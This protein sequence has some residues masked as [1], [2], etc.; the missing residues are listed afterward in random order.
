MASQKVLHSP[1]RGVR[2]SGST[3]ESRV[4]ISSC[5]TRP[6]R[7]CAAATCDLPL[8]SLALGQRYLAAMT[9][10]TTMDAMPASTAL[11]IGDDRI[12]VIGLDPDA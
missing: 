4:E 6:L 1:Q 2:S 11:A 10:L 9:R 3:R 8:L 12:S 7:S 5:W